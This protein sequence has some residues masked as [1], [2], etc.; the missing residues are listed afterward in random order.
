MMMIEHIFKFYMQ[1]ET[2]CLQLDHW[3]VKRSVHEQTLKSKHPDAFAEENNKNETAV[4]LH[5]YWKGPPIG[6][7]WVMQGWGGS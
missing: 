5:V 3:S 6:V 2:A 7:G 4:E 1:I